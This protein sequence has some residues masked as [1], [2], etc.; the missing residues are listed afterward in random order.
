[1]CCIRLTS[2]PARLRSDKKDRMF[3]D[4]SGRR[5]HENMLYGLGFYCCCSLNTNGD[6]K[7]PNLPIRP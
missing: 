3:E 4:R 2:R 1:M 5:K 7:I 6:Q